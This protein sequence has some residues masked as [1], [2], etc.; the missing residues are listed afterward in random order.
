MNQVL[1]LA[2]QTPKK[3][4]LGSRM[5]GDA[6]QAAY[7]AE[8]LRPFRPLEQKGVLES[9]A[10]P[11]LPTGVR[12]GRFAPAPVRQQNGGAVAVSVATKTVSLPYLETQKSTS[13]NK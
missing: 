7:P 10:A 12:Q 6:A 3:K 2:K 1:F 4:D 11:L 13:T 5:K 8:N 9:G